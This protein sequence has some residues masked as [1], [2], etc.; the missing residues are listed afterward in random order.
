MN[1]REFN[2][3]ADILN[4]VNHP[5]ADSAQ[6]EEDSVETHQSA[7]LKTKHF[8]DQ[9]SS[10]NISQQSVSSSDRALLSLRT[11]GK[12]VVNQFSKAQQEGCIYHEER[13]RS[14]TALIEKSVEYD[15][16]KFTT[17]TM[18]FEK[19]VLSIRENVSQSNQF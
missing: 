7:L 10:A 15:S 4:R 18:Q 6:S 9:P 1:R 3:L 8:L 5:A 17:P 14:A 16:V 13:N 2:V 19:S 11:S 12:I